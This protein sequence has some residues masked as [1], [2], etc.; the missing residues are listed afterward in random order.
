MLAR[1]L[2]GCDLSTRAQAYSG[3]QATCFASA[4][5]SRA[6]TIACACPCKSRRRRP[7]NAAQW[8]RDQG[9]AWHRKELPLCLHIRMQTVHCVDSREVYT[10]GL[11]MHT[12]RGCGCLQGS[13]ARSPSLGAASHRCETR[14]ESFARPCRMPRKERSQVGTDPARL[15]SWCIV[16][17]KQID[18]SHDFR[19][20][21]HQRASHR[22]TSYCVGNT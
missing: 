10:C 17:G 9:G 2:A 22:A 5:A 12:Q 7:G 8:R 1:V 13:A 16:P 18:V 15:L 20:C 14:R 6:S 3:T 21:K 4:M 11:G 19:I